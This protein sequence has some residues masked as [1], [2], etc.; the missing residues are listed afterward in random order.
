MPEY[1]SVSLL[2]LPQC[3]SFHLS[4]LW[5]DLTSPV[6]AGHNPE[7]SPSY[8]SQGATERFAGTFDQQADTRL[9]AKCTSSSALSNQA[10]CA[11]PFRELHL[12]IDQQSRPESGKTKLYTQGCAN[13]TDMRRHDSGLSCCQKTPSP[14][15][16][17]S[18]SRRSL[19]LHELQ[20]E[21]S[22]QPRHLPTR[23]AAQVTKLL[24]LCILVVPAVITV[25]D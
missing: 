17:T 21:R 15:T 20:W 8:T 2:E 24:V 18:P 25:K 7:A 22:P 11:T 23:L 9:C 5:G 14:E 3:S 4:L 19:W 12:N 10:L 1:N 16:A 6:Q 13:T